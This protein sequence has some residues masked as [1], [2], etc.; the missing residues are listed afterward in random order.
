MTTAVS[1]AEEIPA[2][3]KFP[4]FT[5][6]L[7]DS[8]TAALLRTQRSEMVNVSGAAAARAP[9]TTGTKAIMEERIL[10]VL[11]MKLRMVDR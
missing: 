8:T 11:K 5:V 10:K 1:A 6:K 3:L 4:G 7:A 9:K 2:Q